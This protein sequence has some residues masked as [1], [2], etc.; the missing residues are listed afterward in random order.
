MMFFEDVVIGE[1]RDLGTH[2]FTAEEIMDFA[3]RYDPQPFHTDLETAKDT[4]FRGLIASGWHTVAIWM[5]LM[6]RDRLDAPSPVPAISPGFADLRWLKPV[7]PGTTLRF[8]SEI[9]GKDEWKPRP[10][11]GL[12]LSN[13]EARDESGVLFLQFTGKLLMARREAP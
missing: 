8:F 12:I 3:R 1:K 9:T 10:A 7:R 4:I 11:F 5:R 6:V 2:S 13:N